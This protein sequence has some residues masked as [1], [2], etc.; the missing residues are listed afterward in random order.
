MKRPVGDPFLLP[1]RDQTPEHR[2]RKRRGTLDGSF[3]DTRLLERV[4]LA[5]DPAID[6]QGKST[7]AVES[8]NNLADPTNPD[9]KSK[10]P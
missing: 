10:A 5:G 4:T 6:D 3:R 1:K 9:A 8:K 7:K 2:I